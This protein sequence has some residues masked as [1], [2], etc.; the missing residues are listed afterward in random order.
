M[1]KN[2]VGRLRREDCPTGRIN[3]IP[4]MGTEPVSENRMRSWCGS[5][6]GVWLNSQPVPPPSTSTIL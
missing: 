2:S 6:P 5:T 3:S 1:G 4:D